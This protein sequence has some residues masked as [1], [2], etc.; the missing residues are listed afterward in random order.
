MRL[1]W[2]CSR[3][4]FNSVFVVA[5]KKTLS[6]NFFP[7]VYNSNFIVLYY[8]DLRVEFLDSKFFFLQNR[9]WGA[10]CLYLSLILIAFSIVG[11]T[12]DEDRIAFN[13]CKFYWCI[14]CNGIKMHVL[15]NTMVDF[16]RV[17]VLKEKKLKS[18]QKINEIL[19]RGNNRK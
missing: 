9:N 15:M 10:C 1:P 8:R 4:V 7:F 14:K 2:F 12:L 5:D 18:N 16:L 17:I 19:F 3:G 13:L 11:K 6:N